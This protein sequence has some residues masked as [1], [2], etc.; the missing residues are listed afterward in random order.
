MTDT[1]TRSPRHPNRAALI[2]LAAYIVVAAV[3]GLANPLWEAFDED[4]HYDYIATSPPARPCP[5]PAT[6]QQRPSG[7][8]SSRRSTTFWGPSPSS[9]PT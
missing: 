4:G 9:R 6:R 3:F 7:R 8:N 5:E 1:T 2:I